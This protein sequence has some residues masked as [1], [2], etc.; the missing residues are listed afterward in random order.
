MSAGGRRH[1]SGPGRARNT[2]GAVAGEA[3]AALEVELAAERARRE[4][5]ERRLDAQAAELDALRAAI[6]STRREEPRAADPALAAA[7]RGLARP[8][9]LVELP[10]EPGGTGKAYWLRRCEGFTVEVGGESLG[11]V[12]AV[13]FGRRHDR[14]DTLIVIRGGHR[15]KPL[16][17][18]VDTVAEIS[19]E[20]AHVTL[21]LDPRERTSRRSGRALAHALVRRL[22]HLRSASF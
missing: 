11:T 10:R 16:L 22:R 7:A 6:A 12:E 2:P 14:P 1:R 19:P 8:G 5:I 21:S 18:P 20:R 15:H 4:A 17:V 13:R 3:I 9:R